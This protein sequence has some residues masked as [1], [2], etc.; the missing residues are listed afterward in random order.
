[1]AFD[2]NVSFNLGGQR[3]ARDFLPLD[4]ESLATVIGTQEALHR[5]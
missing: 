5:G 2:E 3:P 1:V 4:I